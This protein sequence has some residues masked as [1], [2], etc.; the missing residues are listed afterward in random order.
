MRTI[1]ASLA[2]GLLLVAGVGM[3]GWIVDRMLFL[4]TP[5]VDLTPERLGIVAE[6]VFLETEDGVRIH[7]D[8]AQAR[9]IVEGEK[10]RVHNDRGQLFLPAR[11]DPRVEAMC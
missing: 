1:A 4:P 6:E 8:D 2:A 10:V 11:L 7:P 3:P 5:G 9:G